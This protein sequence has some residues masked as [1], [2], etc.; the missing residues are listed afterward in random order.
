VASITLNLLL[1]GNSIQCDADSSDS[2][3]DV[4]ARDNSRINLTMRGNTIS[5]S[6]TA[7]ADI[8]AGPFTDVGTICLDLNSD[9]I[10]ANANTANPDF[11]LE[12]TAGTFHVEGMGAGPNNA[13][14]V[15]SFLD[16]RNNN[17][18]TAIGTGFTN[19]GGAGCPEP[20]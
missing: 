3:L 7:T 10:V 20:L 2:T 16:P 18:V 15:E 12:Q 6:G 9:N 11:V 5:S 14:A 1:E 17:D 19:N 13:A 8:D 4:D